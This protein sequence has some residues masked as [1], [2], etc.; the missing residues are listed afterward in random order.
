MAFGGFF[1]FFLALPA[2]A[3]FFFVFELEGDRYKAWLWMDLSCNGSGM[4]WDIPWHGAS[5]SL[6][7]SREHLDFAP[8]R[9]ELE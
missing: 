7:L 2:S 5:S 6:N 1:F 4:G 8:R 9:N 3:L